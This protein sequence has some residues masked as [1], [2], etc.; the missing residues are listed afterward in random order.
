[1]NSPDNNDRQLLIDANLTITEAL[2]ANSDLVYIIAGDTLPYSN[3][4]RECPKTNNSGA[5]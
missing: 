3:M 4:L 1:M 5:N 2:K